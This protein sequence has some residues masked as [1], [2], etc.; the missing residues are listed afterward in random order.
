MTNL[1][2]LY[3]S[4]ILESNENSY[5]YFALGGNKYAVSIKQVVEVMKLPLLDYPQKLPNNFIGLLNYNNFTINV[6]DLRFYLNIKVTDYSV[7]NQLLIV[8]TDEAIFGL[9]ID[10]V[11]NIISLDQDKI[12]YFPASGEEKILDFMYNHD[13]GTISII[14]LSTLENI[15][16]NGVASLDIDIPSLFPSDDDSRYKLIQ[17]RQALLEKSSFDLAANIFSQDKFISFAIN[18]DTYCINLEYVKE[19]LKNVYITQIP[20]SLDYIAGV[21]ALRGDFFSIIN[22][23]KFIGINEENIESVNNENHVI[24]LEVPELKIGFL[25]D[26]IF[27]IVNIPED[28]ITKS[29]SNT[30]YFLSEIVME[31]KFYTILDIKSILSDERLFIE[32]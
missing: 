17:R 25:V 14:N 19:F 21:I 4:D 12:E 24:I 11:E 27:S 9:L 28:L 18:G 7:S 3:S 26:E 10:K 16:K 15:I 13:S 1:R 22:L 29:T 31:D 8:K 6:L 32:E 20:C 5:L 23:K 30:K 2:T